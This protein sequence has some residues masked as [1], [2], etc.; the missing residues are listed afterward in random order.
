MKTKLKPANRP[1]PKSA[2]IERSRSVKN[3]GDVEGGTI[4]RERNKQS[5]RKITPA[6][7]IGADVSRKSLLSARGGAK[8]S[9]E[10]KRGSRTDVCVVAVVQKNATNIK[11]T[12]RQEMYP[13]RK[14][15]SVIFVQ[16]LSNKHVDA[17]AYSSSVDINTVNNGSSH[18]FNENNNVNENNENEPLPPFLTLSS[19]VESA[20]PSVGFC[21]KL[22][23]TFTPKTHGG[24]RLEDGLSMLSVPNARGYY[25]KRLGGRNDR[26]Y[27]QSFELLTIE[28]DRQIALLQMN[29]RRAEHHFVRFELNPSEIGMDGMY[30]V[31]RV[32]KALF[33]ERFKDDLRD[34]NITRLDAAVDVFKI[35]PDDLMV[36]S[37]SARQSGLFQ[38]SFDKSGRETFVTETHT[39]GSQ[40]SDYFVRCYDKSAQTWR[41][42]AEEVDGLITRIEVKLK[43]RADTGVTLRVGDICKARNPFGALVLTYYPTAEHSNYVFN[44]F[45]AATRSVGAERALKMIPDK[46][47]RSKFWNLLQDSVPNW[48]CPDK[49]WDGV[50]ESL[51]ATGL[52][53]RDI[54]RRK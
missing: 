38:R 21:D 8:R 30:E 7:K 1:L 39:V 28:G 40:S 31:K 23:C 10:R 44:L 14:A 4:E 19:Q 33:G 48:W 11:K 22:S 51:K 42:R 29:P 53:P 41:V 43:P 34:G 6:R 3:Q 52:F 49:Q 35:R 2:K 32:F 17:T 37:T 27:R 47:V 13:P 5:V 54:F 46:R 26:I 25:L 16:L 45:V 15:R 20:A 24:D 9:I 18:P 12:R 36:F 50:L